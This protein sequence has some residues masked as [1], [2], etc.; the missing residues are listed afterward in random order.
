ML[1]LLLAK[2]L[3]LFSL[4]LVLVAPASCLADQALK[5]FDRSVFPE[6]LTMLS[7]AKAWDSGQAEYY[8]LYF[9]VEAGLHTVYLDNAGLIIAERWAQFQSNKHTP[10]YR[11]V[12]Y[13]HG[14][15]Y[16]VEAGE[17]DQLQMFTQKSLNAPIKRKRVDADEL[18]IDAGFDEFIQTHWQA[19]FEKDQARSFEFPFAKRRMMIK[20]KL[21]SDACEPVIVGTACLSLSMRNPLFNLIAGKTQVRYHMGNKQL[22]GFD[23]L[24]PLASKEHKPL[25]V[26]VGFDYTNPEQKLERLAF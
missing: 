7:T 9:E 6:K 1:R 14:S 16:G 21:E 25:K 23:G 12:D 19:L 20:M 15:Q 22:L 26:R 3:S 18:V 17:G 4:I 11:L 2:T 8:E 24:S 10:L 13:R 5:A